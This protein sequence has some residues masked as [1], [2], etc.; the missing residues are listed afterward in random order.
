MAV[1]A[2]VFAGVI[3]VAPSRELFTRANARE[4]ELA[5]VA[6]EFERPSPERGGATRRGRRPP[7]LPAARERRQHRRA[8]PGRG[9]PALLPVGVPG[10]ML[11][12]GDLHFAQGDGEVCISAIETGGSATVRV[13]LRRDGWRPASRP[14]RPRRGRADAYFATTGIPLDDDGRN[15]QLDLNLATRRA[16]IEM[17]GWLEHEHGLGARARLRADERG[18]GAAGVGARGRTERA[19]VGGD[20]ARRVRGDVPARWASP[21][22]GR[23]GGPP[24]PS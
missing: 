10:A 8:R 14:G 13:G 2:G 15:E 23:R 17:L 1:P 24:R 18:G 19:G 16:L 4:A 11:S 21:G 22:P 3:G 7:H 12:L 5:A 20:A 9:Q 6:A